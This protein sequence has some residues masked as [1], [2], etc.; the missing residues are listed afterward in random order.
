MA[1][2]GQWIRLLLVV[3]VAIFSSVSV[4]SAS[5]S[6]VDD[7]DAQRGSFLQ[8]RYNY[9]EVVMDN[10][11]V[12]VTLSSP[13]G[14]VIGISYN[15]MDNLLERRNRITNRGYFDLVW[16]SAG[17]RTG[18]Y[19][20][21]QG[22]RMRI[23][24]Q[25]EDVL[26]LSFTRE[27][28]DGWFEGMAPLNVDRRYV[29]LRNTSG[30]YT[31]V[32]VDR[33]EGLPAFNLGSA[34][35]AFKLNMRNFQYMAVSDTRRRIMPTAMDRNRG[36]KLGYPEAVLL[37]NPYNRDLTGEVDDKYQYSVESQNDKVHGW[38]SQNP[39]IGFWMITPSYEFRT[40][41]PMKQ[42]LTSHVGP[43]TLGA[44]ISDHYGGR[45]VSTKFQDGESWKKVFGPVMI[46]VNSAPSSDI[47]A[48]DNLWEDAKRQMEEEVQKWP[49]DFIQSEDYP[50]SSQRGTVSGQLNV[51][52]R[53]V[54]ADD[55]GAKL[56][57]VG[58]A[59]PGEAGSWEKETKGY[60]FWTR[61]DENGHFVIKNV[62][63]GLYNLYAWVPGFLGDYK[64]E[65]DIVIGSGSEI[66]LSTLVFT[67][68]R[69]GP[70]L[71][72]IGIPDRSAAE[73]YVPE[74]NPMY[75]NKVLLN[76]YEDRFRQ[77][78]L[79]ER[80]ADIYG[81]ED[82]VYTVGVS[83][84]STDWFYA[85]V[86]RKIDDSTYSP[87]TRLINFEL[88]QLDYMGMYTL[89]GALAAS[90]GAQLIF[91][92]NDNN[93]YRPR[94]ATRAGGTDNA[95]ARHG[96]HGLYRLFSVQVPGYLLR[97]GSNTIYVT[98]PRAI[99]PYE[100]LMYDY[101]RLEGPSSVV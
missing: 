61:A 15:G 28:S 75:I 93:P 49:Y 60:Q 10:G 22:T 26:E 31:Y 17:D 12:Q 78:G 14:G 18:I 1:S 20:N 99:G 54:S 45:E 38:I 4:F 89:Q 71:W 16:N 79:W 19:D 84:Y 2:R 44:F 33:E 11:I 21:V 96:I 58:L 72:E 13:G 83:N 90:T 32:I 62:R 27:W 81:V 39:S 6:A 53:Y 101:I 70:T 46:Y 94:L 30:F 29:M 100:G 66:N 59:L 86:T 97:Q 55:F 73:F 91:Q 57:Y 56:A 85:H 48:Y 34:R 50:G 69:Q 25:T 43:T 23:V 87:T 42:D 37:T 68:P 63:P 5:S 64:Y 74:P 35:V 8:L 7:N 24:Q 82:P 47:N 52:D 51:R 80:Y 67:P 41:G 40:G 98:Q 88:D 36:E 65:G 9:G 92:V 95:I 76:S 3:V 77:Y